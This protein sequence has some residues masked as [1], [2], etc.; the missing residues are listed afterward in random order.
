MEQHSWEHVGRARFTLR[1][2]FPHLGSSS[3]PQVP[4]ERIFLTVQQRRSSTAGSPWRERIQ[5]RVIHFPTWVALLVHR[6]LLREFFLLF[7]S[8]GAAQLGARGESPLYAVSFISL[9]GLSFSSTDFYSENFSYC[10]AAVEQH[11]WEHV[12]RARF[13]PR[14]SFPHLGSSSRPQ[15]PAERIFLT[16]QQWWSSTAGSTW[17][18]R[19]LRCVIHF[20]TWVVLLVLRFLLREFFL[21]CSSGGAAQLGARGESAH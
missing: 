15:V 5:G 12:A 20:P 9:P 7:S 1:H 3:R 17:R 11:S 13:M 8:G 16:V 19:A 2:S 18:E 14:H 6:F 10:A 4:A 21:L